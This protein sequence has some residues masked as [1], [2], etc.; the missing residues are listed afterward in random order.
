MFVHAHTLGQRSSIVLRVISE[1]LRPIVRIGGLVQK[2][3]RAGVMGKR[4]RVIRGI[5]GAFARMIFIEFI[6]QKIK[7]YGLDGH[8]VLGDK[9]RRRPVVVEWGHSPLDRR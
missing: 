5:V 1:T 6:E 4:S 2:I 3:I 7:S 8:R 9:Y